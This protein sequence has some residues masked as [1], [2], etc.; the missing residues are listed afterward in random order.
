MRSPL[1]TSQIPHGPDEAS[2][3]YRPQ[4]RHAASVGGYVVLHLSLLDPTQRRHRT[5]PDHMSYAHGRNVRRQRPPARSTAPS[6]SSTLSIC[7]Q[8]TRSDVDLP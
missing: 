6:T 3:R 2:S 7:T 5:P 4:E 1:Q 8:L